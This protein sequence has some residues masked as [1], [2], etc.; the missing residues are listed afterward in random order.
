MVEA[1][2]GAGDH[3]AVDMVGP[4]HVAPSLAW[5]A[6]PDGK[7]RGLRRFPLFLAVA[8]TYFSACAE[9]HFA[10]GLRPAPNHA[11][12][13]E[14]GMELIAYAALLFEQQLVFQAFK[15]PAMQDA[16]PVGWEHGRIG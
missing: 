3:R 10:C 1:G 7:K 14:E 12:V 11:L 13:W 9:G 6:V 2:R 5:L 15:P 8:S 4:D 16:Y